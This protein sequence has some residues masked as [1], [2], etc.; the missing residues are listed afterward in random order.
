MT[1]FV[2]D[3][4]R[5]TLS[6]LA[7]KTLNSDCIIFGASANSKL[8]YGT[9]INRILKNF[10]DDFILNDDLLKLDGEKWTSPV[11]LN[12]VVIDILNSIKPEFYLK[13]TSSPTTEKFVKCLLETF[14]RLPF[15]DREKLILKEDII[16]KIETALKDK[17]N[18]QLQYKGQK[19][20]ITPICI[21]PSKEG[22]FQYLIGEE[23]SSRIS[24]RLSRIEK[25]RP[26]GKAPIISKQTKY[27]IFEDLSEFGATFITQPIIE[28]KVKF[29]EKGLESYK[30]S[31]IHRPTHIA[32]EDNNVL[33]FRCSEMQALYFFF[34]FAKDAE[35]I[36]P[37]SLR[38]SFRQLYREGLETYE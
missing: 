6:K 32:A 13:N 35:I 7:K 21:S 27:Q 9:L 5:I 23:N 33:I 22:T 18:L 37:L 2:S 26:I 17:K 3:H 25:I 11:Y 30:Y 12:K 16:Q 14:T 34:R 15:I 8:T 10:D 1:E 36:E 31:V 38:N 19:H 4:I 20:I 24:F 28:V 29:T